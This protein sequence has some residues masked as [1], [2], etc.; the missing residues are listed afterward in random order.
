[1]P[2]YVYNCSHNVALEYLV[3]PRPT[4]YAALN[5]KIDPTVLFYILIIVPTVGS[6][7]IVCFLCCCIKKK[8]INRVSPSE[9]EETVLEE[10]PTVITN[11]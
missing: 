1:V 5:S 6:S 3:C 7:I 8:K 4:K 11:D 10:D 2:A 9:K